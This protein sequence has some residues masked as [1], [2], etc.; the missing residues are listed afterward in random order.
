[1]SE[2][3]GA[4]G[5]QRLQMKLVLIITW[6]PGVKLGESEFE[7]WR[8]GCVCKSFPFFLH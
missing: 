8:V 2:F 6:F 1:M 3:Q 7:N 4:G 5:M